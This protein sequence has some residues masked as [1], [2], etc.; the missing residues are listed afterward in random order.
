[1]NIERASN[2]LE[3]G[4]SAIVLFTRDLHL[5]INSDGSGTSGY[6]RIN[7]GHHQQPDKVII[8]NR[9]SEQV[10]REAHIYLATYVAAVE[11]TRPGRYVIEFQ[12]GTPVGSS[13]SSWHEF[14]EAGTNPVRYLTKG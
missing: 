1:M 10:R 9:V 7:L 11:S 14:A 3:S 12:G 8:Y 2:L 6:W 5:T 13:K 4:E